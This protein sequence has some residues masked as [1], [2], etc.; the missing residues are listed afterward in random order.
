MTCG[1]L[2]DYVQ[3]DVFRYGAKLDDM[4]KKLRQALDEQVRTII[5]CIPNR[6]R[7][8]HAVWIQVEPDEEDD[9]IGDDVML[10]QVLLAFAIGDSQAD[11]STTLALQRRNAGY[12]RHGR[13]LGFGRDGCNTE[14]ALAGPQIQSQIGAKRVGGRVYTICCTHGIADFALR[15]PAYRPEAPPLEY[16]G[17][18]PLIPLTPED[19]PFQI[20]ILRPFYLEKVAQARAQVQAARELAE[21]EGSDMPMDIEPAVNAL[22]DQEWDPTMTQLGAFGQVVVRNVGGGGKKPQEKKE[23]RKIKRAKARSAVG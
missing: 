11:I 22:A 19:I 14:E 4:H 20:G 1:E 12:G 5:S 8:V 7:R 16:P 15:V 13:F 2:D 21:A 9:E 18:P 6:N 23:E 3:D 17:P 10:L